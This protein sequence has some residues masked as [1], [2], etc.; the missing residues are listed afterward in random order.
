MIIKVDKEDLINLVRGTS[1][2]NYDL[3]EHETVK[4][5]GRFNGSQGSWHWN[6]TELKE[7]TKIQLY[8][9]YRMCKSSFEN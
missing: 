8:D 2:N 5:C 1:P 7:L 3:F 9:L 6:N 4:K